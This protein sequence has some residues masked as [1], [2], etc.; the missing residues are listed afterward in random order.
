MEKYIKG[1]QPVA[2]TSD[3]FRAWIADNALRPQD[4][5]DEEFAEYVAVKREEYHAPHKETS[6]DQERADR[7]TDYLRSLAI[8][9]PTVLQNKKILDYGCFEGAFVRELLD[10]NITKEA[11]GEDED[12]SILPKGEKYRGHFSDYDEISNGQKYDLITSLHLISFDNEFPIEKI[13]PSFAD[14]IEKLVP[15][16]ELRLGYAPLAREEENV[17]GIVEQ[18]KQLQENLPRMAGH[19]GFTYKLIPTDIQVCETDKASLHVWLNRVL[20]IRKNE[21]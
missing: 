3:A 14:V 8:D 20:I 16:G 17:E 6:S 19:Y 1:G 7:Y 2:P 21:A 9:D 12:A 13:E 15:G 4:K 18:N 11:Y 10:H 5:W